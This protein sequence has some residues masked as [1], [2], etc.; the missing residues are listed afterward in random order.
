MTKY[1]DYVSQQIIDH[2]IQGWIKE[3]FKCAYDKEWSTQETDTVNKIDDQI[4][5]IMLAR[6][7]YCSPRKKQHQPWSP[8]QRVIAR[9]FSYWKQ[10]LMMANKKVFQWGHLEQPRHHTN[11]TN[12]DHHTRDSSYIYEQMCM[13]RAKWRVYKKKS[14]KLRRQFLEEC[15]TFFASKL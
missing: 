11:I 7:R 14:A 2:Q 10:K 3:L 6:E 1:I 4:T 8:Q 9:T 13:S 5:S 12:M 15:A